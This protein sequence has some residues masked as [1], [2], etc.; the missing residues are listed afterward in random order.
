MKEIKIP[1]VVDGRRRDI[2]F[3]DVKGYSKYVQSFASFDNRL[4]V[5]VTYK[6]DDLYCQFC[7]ENKDYI[8]FTCYSSDLD[9]EIEYDFELA[10]AEKFLSFTNY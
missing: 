5:L 4:C 10:T 2:Y 7:L 1:Y 3:N 6:R 8:T 9:T